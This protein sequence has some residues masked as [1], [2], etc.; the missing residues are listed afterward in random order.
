MLKV[1]VGSF[2]YIFLHSYYICFAIYIHEYNW[3]SAIE[4]VVLVASVY[5]YIVIFK[6]GQWLVGGAELYYCI[7]LYSHTRCIR[8]IDGKYFDAQRKFKV[9]TLMMSGRIPIAST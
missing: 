9:W 6:E 2:T 8:I 1:Y 7:I 5:L 4:G 3:S